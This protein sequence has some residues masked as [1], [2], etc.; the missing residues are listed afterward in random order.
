MKPILLKFSGINS[1][2][3]EYTVP[4]EELTK[5]GIFGIFG[6]TGSGKST[7][8]DAI[9]LALYGK[10]PRYIDTQHR[11]FINTSSAAAYVELEF[12]IM[13]AGAEKRYIVKRGYKQN[14]KGKPGVSI[15]YC[16]LAEVNGDILADRKENEVTTAVTDIVGLNY[17]DFTRSVFLPQGKFSEFIFL[18]GADREKMLERLFSLEEF[19]KNLQAKIKA[20]ENDA[21][22]KLDICNMQIGFYGDISSDALDIKKQQDKEMSDKIRTLSLERELFLSS[23]EKYKTLDAAY[24]KLQAAN[25][26]LAKQKSLQESYDAE[27]NALEAAVRAEKL[28]IPIETIKSLQN[29]A[30]QAN[31]ELKKYKEIADIC[32]KKSIQLENEYL[33]ARKASAEEYPELFKLEQK[34]EL[35]LVMLKEIDALE[36]EVG[37]LRTDW[38]HGSEKLISFNKIHANAKEAHRLLAE[39]ASEIAVKKEQLTVPADV[40]R[41]FNEGTRLESEFA[42]N[43]KNIQKGRQ[44]LA[45]Y[46]KIND[47]LCP[48]LEGMTK[49]LEKLSKNKAKSIASD[50]AKTLADNSPCPVCGSVHHPNPAEDFSGFKQDE[51]LENLAEQTEKLKVKYAQN[52]ARM[53]SAANILTDMQDKQDICA[54]AIND[55]KAIMPG[56]NNF[57]QALEEAFDKNANKTKLEAEEAALVPQMDAKLAEMQAQEVNAAKIKA[58]L[59]VLLEKGKEKAAVIAEKKAALGEYHDLETVQAAINETKAAMAS[60]VAKEKETQSLKDKHAEEALLNEKNLA[61]LTERISGLRTMEEEQQKL[62]DKALLEEGFADIFAAEDA[63]VDAAL[64]IE[65]EERNKEFYR[66][67]AELEN[68]VKQLEELLGDEKDSQNIS[69]KLQ[70]SEIQYRK[71]DTELI[72]YREEHAVLADDINRMSE[73]LQNAEKLAKERKLL[74]TRHGI[75]KEIESLFRANAFIKFL[76]SHQLRYVTA[77]ATSR[78]KRMTA[79]QYAIECDEDA[80]FYIRDDFAGGAYR[81]PASLSGGEA[82]MTSLCLALALSTKIQMK[83]PADLS[84]FF[85]DEGFGSLDRETLDVVVDA[86]EQ[87][88]SENMVVGL[89][90][91]VEEMKNRII[92]KIELE[93]NPGKVNIGG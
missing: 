62:A 13:Q 14:P 22:N 87:L 78:L 68:T 10:V 32:R 53:E 36:E 3:A 31:N 11:T 27:K 20:A 70:Q 52:L 91:H 38:K 26:Q 80:N 23:W 61:S 43:E 5:G 88:R 12:E 81:P 47:D 79:G 21:R 7:I 50:L 46:E 1:Y 75:I 89:I 30:A 74:E 17:Q 54:K 18:K 69:E 77:E 25:L 51:Y 67:K 42:V 55:L 34:L 6:P 48:K 15:T 60:I 86:L 45:K 41:N 84:F 33:E 58:D 37:S 44:E 93:K 63:L 39:R 85:L 29:Q 82:F 59:D 73:N 28:R 92:N 57:S 19:G 40:F 66:F 49:E 35:H 2:E 56:V 8:L 64:R 76:A 24:K 71:A 72:T 9:T 4:F 90:T 65:A 16:S 83:S